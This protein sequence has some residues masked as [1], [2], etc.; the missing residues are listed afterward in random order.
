M[1]T[2]EATETAAPATGAAPAIHVVLADAM[3]AVDAVGKGGFNQHGKYAFRGIDQVI[4]AV[5]PVFRS[6]RIVPVPQL[7]NIDYRDVQTSNGK[8]SR[9][10]TLQ[11]TYRF[12]GPAGDFV[13]VTVP[14]ESMDSADKGTAQ[15]MSVAYRTALLQLLCIP[16]DE[17]DPDSFQP[18]RGAPARGGRVR[19]SFDDAQP[20]APAF[21]P[22]P[23][24]QELMASVNAAAHQGAL[25]RVWSRAVEAYKKDVITEAE[26]NGLRA[27]V[28]EIGPGL[29]PAPEESPAALEGELIENVSPA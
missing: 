16:T 27:K 3:I 21:Q 15:A 5:G 18:E 19:E 6:L 20:A 9:E 22:G 4:N 11:V 13:D 1:D 23:E 10:T 28:K 2:L 26:A 17:P 8:P 25:A 29:P 14:G 12:Y 24:A 7:K